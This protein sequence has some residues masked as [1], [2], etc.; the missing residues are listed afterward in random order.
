[1]AKLS[2]LGIE[3]FTQDDGAMW[4]AF[5]DRHDTRKN[6]DFNYLIVTSSGREFFLGKTMPYAGLKSYFQRY[7][8]G[9]ADPTSTTFRQ[10]LGEGQQA[11]VHSMGSKLAVRE[12]AGTAH[13]YKAL[14]DLTR[15]DLLASLIEGGVPRW[16]S[17]P[18]VY[19]HYSDQAAGKQYTLMDRVDS[20][21]NADD[22][23]NFNVAS[24]HGKERVLRELGREPSDQDIETVSRLF[25]TAE[26]I[27]IGVIE[28]KGKDPAEILTDWAPRNVLVEPLATP[29]GGERFSINIIDQ[30]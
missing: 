27:L 8:N 14:G 22:I 11:T 28:S 29:I 24:E 20:G 12:Q 3:R 15:M 13:F 25:G 7:R 1:M 5:Y 16:I 6:P 17:T 30:N 21:M 23:L 9:E 4:T 26:S 19:A 2:N 10:F 18:H